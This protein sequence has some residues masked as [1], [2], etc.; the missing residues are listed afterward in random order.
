MACKLIKG[1]IKPCKGMD[2]VLEQDGGVGTRKQGAKL[3]TL[4]NF[5][6]GKFSRQWIALKSGEHS[7]SGIVMNFCPF[8]GEQIFCE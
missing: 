5:K 8:C 4:I 7:K 1:R 3:Q 2:G 6:S